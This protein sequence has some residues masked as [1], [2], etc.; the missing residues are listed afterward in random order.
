MLV[1]VTVMLACL[2]I[3]YRSGAAAHIIPAVTGLALTLAT[4]GFMHEPVNLFHV[5]SLLL[6]LGL[7]VDYAIILRQGAT[8][9]AVLA[10]FLSMT[11][12]LISFGLPVFVGGLRALHR[13][14]GRRGVA[15]TFLIAVAAADP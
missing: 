4:L 15:Y 14:H 12:T 7:S 1:V 2:L 6:V 8:I 3:F 5:L 9:G 13:Y 10:V 11:T